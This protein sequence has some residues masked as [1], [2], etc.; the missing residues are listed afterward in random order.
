MTQTA[1]L[2]I[3]SPEQYLEAEKTSPIKHE[4]VNG[5]I[6]SMAGASDAHGTI[7]ANL[8]TLLRPQL[9]GTPCRLYPTDMKVKSGSRNRYYYPDLLV[10]CDPRDRESNYF[11]QYPKL[12]IEVLSSST[13]AFDRGDKFDDYSDI[14]TL[15]EYV[16]VS[17][18]HHRIDCFRRNPAGIWFLRR[19]RLGDQ[20]VLESIGFRAEVAQVYEDFEGFVP[21]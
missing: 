20:L 21:S 17:Q 6:Y 2:V 3:L 7:V 14:A 10:T 15:E 16:L 13:E 19:Y 18:K 12:I 11:K 5:E 9:R 8:T 4:Y 1:S